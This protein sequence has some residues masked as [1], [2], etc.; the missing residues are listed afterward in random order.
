M[1]IQRKM[2]DSVTLSH[3]FTF[4]NVSFCDKYNLISNVNKRL[5]D[6]W[7]RSIFMHVILYSMFIL[8][9]RVPWL[10]LNVFGA[11]EWLK[12]RVVGYTPAPISSNGIFLPASKAPSICNMIQMKNIEANTFVY[13]RFLACKI[14]RDKFFYPHY[15]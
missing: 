15:T 12:N 2:V 5:M 6:K 4:S 14:L 1:T 10:I 7:F 11:H 9:T 3:F 13:Y 8:L